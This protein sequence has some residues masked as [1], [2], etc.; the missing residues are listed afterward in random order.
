MKVILSL[1][2]EPVVVG[3]VFG[4]LIGIYYPL[5]AF[6]KLLLLVGALMVLRIAVAKS[7]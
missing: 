6:H 7:K 4:S 3:I 1:L 2:D 5:V